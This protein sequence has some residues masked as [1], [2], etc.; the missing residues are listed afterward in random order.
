MTDSEE[1]RVPGDELFHLVTEVFERCKMG[2]RD[3]SLL[4]GTLCYADL[5]AVHSHGV[6][7]VPEY[8]GKLTHGGGYP[9]LAEATR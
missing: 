7:R 9:W 6:L 5:T 1:T 4:A 2:T 8:V 3:A